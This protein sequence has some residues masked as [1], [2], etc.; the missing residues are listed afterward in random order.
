MNPAPDLPSDVVAAIMGELPGAGCGTRVVPDGAGSL[1]LEIAVRMPDSPREITF[2]VSD[3]A[4]SSRLVEETRVPDGV[5]WLVKSLAR[6]HEKQSPD[7]GPSD[8]R[9]G[10]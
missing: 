5:G 9:P 3:G 4:G 7:S 6:A 10:N 1:R 8:T 2:R